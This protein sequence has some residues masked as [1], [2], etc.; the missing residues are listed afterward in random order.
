[1]AEVAGNYLTLAADKESLKIA[2]DTFESQQ[3]SYNLIKRRFEAGA[4]S[5]LDV[6]QAQTSVDSARVDIARFTSLVAQDE[7][8]L[9]L[10]IG[11]PIPADLLPSGLSTITALKELSAGL[12]SEVLQRRPTS[13]NQNTFS[14]PPMPTSVL[15]ARLFSRALLLRR[16]LVF[17]AISWMDSLREIPGHGVLPADYPADF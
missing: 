11:S 8:A 17:Q 13:Y 12:P 5:E 4:S 2:R 3:A 6:R 10:V 9:A 14:R 7:N 15:H 1:V 16:A